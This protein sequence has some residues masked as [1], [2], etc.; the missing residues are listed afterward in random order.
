VGKAL[1]RPCAD[2]HYIGLQRQQRSKVP[3]REVFEGGRSGC[4]RFCLRLQYHGTAPTLAPHHDRGRSP[5]RRW[6]DGADEVE[7]VVFLQVEFHGLT[8]R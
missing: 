4:H 5:V 2:Q 7:R 3:L 8:V 1:S 6:L